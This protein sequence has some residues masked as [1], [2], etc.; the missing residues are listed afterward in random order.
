MSDI[1]GGQQVNPYTPAPAIGSEL[2]QQIFKYLMQTS[3]MNNG[4]DAQ[5]NPTGMQPF[6]MSPFPGLQDKSAP[7]YMSPDIKSTMLP[8]VWGGWNPQ[9]SPGMQAMDK[10]LGGIDPYKMDPNLATMM[11]WGGPQGP[12][13]DAMN[14]FSQFGASGPAGQFA[15]NLAQF[16]IAS[17]TSGRPLVD[18][19]YGKFDSGPAAILAPFLSAVSGSGGGY[20]AP[21]IE[22]TPTERKSK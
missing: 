12:G 22:I 11:R 13:T 5:G 19:A 21:S 16:G 1:I 9:G 14:N 2:Q 20:R 8:Q 17:E 6:Q 3:G 4:T 18:L 10:T 15:N 7:Q